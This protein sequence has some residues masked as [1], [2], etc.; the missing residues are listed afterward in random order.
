MTSEYLWCQLEPSTA[1]L[2]ACL[3]TYRPLFVNINFKLPKISKYFR[4]TSSTL[5]DTNDISIA[6]D[7]YGRDIVKLNSKA[8]DNDLHIVH[9]RM[10]S[11]SAEDG[12]PEIKTA[13]TDTS[14][15]KNPTEA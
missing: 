1:I 11:P 7:I 5:T 2:C 3:V 13:Q 9:V 12:L 10:V 6:E 4:Q 15:L 14:E 8:A